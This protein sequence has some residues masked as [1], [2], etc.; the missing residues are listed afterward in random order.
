[1]SRIAGVVLVAVLMALV[2]AFP[3]GARVQDPPKTPTAVGYGGSAAIVDPLATQAAIDILRRGGNAVDAA[4]AAA[5]VLGVVEP[6]SCGIGGG[7]FMVI[8]DAKHRHVDTIDSRETAPHGHAPGR[9]REVDSSATA[10]FTEARASAASA[11]ASPAP[12]AGWET[13]LKR[14]G[15]RR[16]SSLLRPAERIARG[17]FRI[18][19]TFNQQVADNADV[20]DDFTASRE[21]YLTRAKTAQAGRHHPAQPGHGEDV[22]A[23]RRGPGPLLQ[24]PDRARHRAD[25]PAPAGGAR[26]RPPAPDH[27]GLDD[28]ARPRALRA[29]HREPTKIDYRGL[30]VYGMAPAVLRRLDGRRGAQ[31]PR[32]LPAPRGAHEQKL[33]RYLEASK[34]AYA[35]RGKYVGDPAYVKP[36]VPL[37][38]LLSDGF[39]AERRSLISDT[40]LP[41]PQ[42]TRATRGRT[43]V[44]GHGGRGKPSSDDEGP[45]TTHLTVADRWGNVVTYTFTIEQIG[46]SGITVPG[47][48]FLLNNELTDFNLPRPR[49]GELAG[50]GQAPALEHGADARVRPRAPRDRARLAGRRDDHHHRAADPRQPDR[51]RA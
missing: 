8:Y 10:Q 41:A 28:A 3:A 22:R 25:R 17:G 40:A 35:D 42:A 46:G 16:L 24:R 9:L 38:G 37:R 44:S 34:L 13:A 33:H 32:G 1:M 31:H 39:A 51:L 18:D 30:D 47:R 29:I 20:F 2:A 4:V 49:H 27:A 5:G 36:S 7:G 43:T 48:G 23:H 45:S 14:Y 19:Q 6:F 15:T 26:L 12:C 11:S 50:P 21:L